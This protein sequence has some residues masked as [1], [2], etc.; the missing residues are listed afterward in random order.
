[1]WQTVP[2]SF[3]A[4]LLTLVGIVTIKLFHDQALRYSHYINSFA[5]GIILTVAIASLL[6]HAV[7]QNRHA[8]LYAL[9]G[10]AAFLVLETFLVLHS[11]AEVHYPERSNGA[12]R[13]IVFFWGL[14]LHSLLDG[15]IIAAAFAGGNRIGLVTTLAVV[16]HELPEGIT[17]FALLLRK[18]KERTAMSLAIAVALATPVGGLIGLDERHDGNRGQAG[19]SEKGLH[20]G[21][22]GAL[23]GHVHDQQIGALGGETVCAEVKAVGPHAPAGLS[24][25]LNGRDVLGLSRTDDDDRVHPSERIGHDEPAFVRALQPYGHR[26]DAVRVVGGR[27]KHPNGPRARD[28]L[29]R[30]GAGQRKATG[31]LG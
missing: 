20:D 15:V 22:D 28:D 14:F 21:P 31:A 23:C 2:F 5:A 29:L 3:L 10:F 8:G 24:E 13:G 30:I 11:G 19:R 1:M 12:A 6:P 16:S 7:E 25:D 18:L 27:H 26:H 4:G 9:G 17:T